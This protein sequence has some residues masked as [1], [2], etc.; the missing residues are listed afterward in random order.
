MIIR[1]SATDARYV[2]N[3][4]VAMSLY[5]LADG[6][7]LLKLRIQYMLV[8]SRSQLIASLFW[9]IVSS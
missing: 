3:T 6:L 9:L 2:G 1:T 8:T 4:N 7:W 5:R